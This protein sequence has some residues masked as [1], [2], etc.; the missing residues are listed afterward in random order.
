MCVTCKTISR[1]LI[2]CFPLTGCISLITKMVRDEN[3]RGL[4]RNWKAI[5]Q[6]NVPFLPSEITEIQT[7]NFNSSLSS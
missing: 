5:M 1:N 3:Y 7:L 4:A 6:Q 2:C